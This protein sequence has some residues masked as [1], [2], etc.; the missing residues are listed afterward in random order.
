MRFHSYIP[1]PPLCDFIEDIRL[2]ENYAGKHVRERILPSGTLAMIFNL[3]DDELRIYHPSDP[4]QPRRFSGALLSGAYAETFMTDIAE[5]AST[6]G[7]HFKPGGAFPVLSL[8]TGELAN[9]HIDLRAIWGPAATDLHAQLCDLSA[10]SERFLHVERALMARFLDP[11]AQ[12]GA[13]RA[14]LDLLTRP[15]G[16]VLVRDVAKAVDLSE[17]RFIEVFTAQVGLTPKAFARVQRFQRAM[18]LSRSAA[19]PDWA[20]LA[21][22]CGYFDQ[23]HLIRDFVAFSGVSPTDYWRRQTQIE[24]AG[25]RVK[26]NHLP[27]RE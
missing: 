9:A 17:R 6:L 12:H 25:M 15:G 1:R 18:A 22:E 5:E 7:V 23:A 3:R 14:G 21:I 16:R 20:R 26:R 2:Y 10:P 13:I 19:K 8:A 11:P 24:R 27:L 4:S